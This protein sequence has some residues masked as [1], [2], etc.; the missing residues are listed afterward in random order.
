MR[1]CPG[2]L[3]PLTKV[4]SPKIVAETQRFHPAFTDSCPNRGVSPSSTPSR[5][6]FSAPSNRGRS[7]ASSLGSLLAIVLVASGGALYFG[8]EA[9][10]SMSGVTQV[11]PDAHV[12]ISETTQDRT[13]YIEATLTEAENAGRVTLLDNTGEPVT[14]VKGGPAVFDNP[15]GQI[16]Q[17]LRIP[18]S[19]INGSRLWV[20]AEQ[21]EQSKVVQQIAV[22]NSSSKSGT[23]LAR[24]SPT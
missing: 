17:M 15:A 9:G 18:R 13:T 19:T 4:L 5:T 11:A 23:R 21:G 24:V 7:T 1:L 2:V 8:L 16:G 14:T 22:G 6:G 12:S 3:A 10:S 20:R